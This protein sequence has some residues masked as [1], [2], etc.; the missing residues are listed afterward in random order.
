MRGIAASAANRRDSSHNDALD[1]SGALDDVERLGVAEQFFDQMM[2]GASLYSDDLHAG[3]GE[4]L[5]GLG[6]KHL[7]HRGVDNVRNFPVGFPGGA[8]RHQPRGAQLTVHRFQPVADPNGSDGARRFRK[9]ERLVIGRA[10]HPD[11]T[12]G[13]A[14]PGGIE[15]AHGLRIGARPRR[16]RG[17]FATQDIFV[18][19]LAIFEDERDRFIGPQPH[20]VFDL[21]AGHAAVAVLDEEGA[22]ACATFFRIEIGLDQHPIGARGIADKAFGAAQQITAIGAGRAGPE[23][24]GVG[25]A[26]RLGQRK[27]SPARLVGTAER[28]EKTL[29]LIRRA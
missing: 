16:L 12:R 20:L 23:R 29:A 21:D 8:Q 10:R 11:R 14:D 27:A 5:R 26:A 2:A 9:T 1:L 28:P 19:H 3:A 15:R 4:V 24:R 13:D 25:A 6:G 17:P 18:R 7:G 22:L